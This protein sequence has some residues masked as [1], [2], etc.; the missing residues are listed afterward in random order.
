MPVVAYN[1]KGQK[2]VFSDLA[3]KLLGKDKGGWT[4]KP[5]QIIE[6]KPKVEPPFMGPPVNKEPQIL[7]N[8]VSENK[9]EV[10]EETNIDNADMSPAETE[11][12]KSEKIKSDF[13]ESIKGVNKTII[14]D[15]FDSQTPPV[16]YKNKISDEN[17]QKQFAEFLN[18]DTVKLQ[19]IIG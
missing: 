19:H 10:V 13:L 14:K 17:L 18:Y 9:Q 7:E 11:E 5:S 12:S 16:K 3:W 6:N 8:N 1:K 15:F 2:Q 4:E